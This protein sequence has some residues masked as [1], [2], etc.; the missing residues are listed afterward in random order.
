LLRT[1]DLNY[2][3]TFFKTD[4]PL[5]MELL[6]NTLSLVSFLTWGEEVTTGF[7]SLALKA[8]FRCKGCH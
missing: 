5:R 7:F 2:H 8:R 4:V 3:P 6:V 1:S